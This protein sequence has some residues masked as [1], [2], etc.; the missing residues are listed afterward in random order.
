M[1]LAGL[2]TARGILTSTG[3]LPPVRLEGWS[4]NSMKIRCNHHM[5]R[6]WAALGVT[7]AV[8]VFSQEQGTWCTSQEATCLPLFLPPPP[9]CMALGGGQ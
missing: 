6:A 9:I 8:T 5:K 3:L 1:A 4:H 2:F 7:S